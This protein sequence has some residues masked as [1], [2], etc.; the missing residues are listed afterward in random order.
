MVN[1]GG[2]NIGSGNKTYIV[3]EIGVNHNGDMDLVKKL[4]D[5]AY[6]AGVDA[7]KFQKF[8]TESLVTKEAQK[9]DIK[10]KLQMLQN[11][12]LIC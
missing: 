12:N 2:K 6:N 7:I 11:H 3:A 10:K 1:I 8:K 4:I 9:Q 5:E